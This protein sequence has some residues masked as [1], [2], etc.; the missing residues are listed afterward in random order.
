MTGKVGHI[1]ADSVDFT[2]KQGFIN[3]WVES[4]QTNRLFTELN[5][6]LL[7]SVING[8]SG[9][10]VNHVFKRIITQLSE[11]IGEEEATDAPG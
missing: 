4:Y 3:T 10:H 2:S 7:D 11:N 8:Y 5:S 6:I 9:E 1:I